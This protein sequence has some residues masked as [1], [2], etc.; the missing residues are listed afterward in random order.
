MS[1]SVQPEQAA[2]YCNLW[3]HDDAFSGETVIFNPDK[4]PLG[5][6]SLWKLVT[7][8]PGSAFVSHDFQGPAGP[9][10]VS[11]TTQGGAT[12]KSSIRKRSGHGKKFNKHVSSIENQTD[13]S[14]SLVFIAQE[15]TAEQKRKQPGLQLSIH[16]SAAATFGFRNRTQVVAIPVDQ[17][18]YSASHVEVSFRDQY[19]ARSDMWRLTVSELSGRSVYKGQRIL[20]MGTVKATV[21]NIYVAGKTVSSACFSDTT[22]PIF[23]SES[24]K[25][26]VF[27][28]MSRE[29]WDFDAEGSGEIMFNKVINGFLP[30][31]FKRWQKMS[32]HHTVSII[33]FTRMEYDQ[34]VLVHRDDQLDDES[35]HRRT[36]STRP[37]FRDYY[38][39]VTTDAASGQ[40]I[41]IL[42]RL[43]REFLVFL[44][45][46]S[47]VGGGD[48]YGRPPE[49]L[50]SV[51]ASANIESV[52]AGQPTTAARGNILEAINLASSQFSKDYIDRDL[53]RTGIS[54]VI[55]TAGT[56]VF[57][58]DYN[59]LKLTTDSLVASGIGVDLVSLARMP[60]HSVPLFRYRSPH[61]LSGMPTVPEI[62]GTHVGNSPRQASFLEGSAEAT[63]RAG[64][65]FSFKSNNE[66]SYPVFGT[67]IE[68]GV[69]WSYALPH[70]IDVSFWTGHSDEANI[71]AQHGLVA[72]KKKHGG[73]HQRRS[74]TTSCRMY[75]LQMMGLMENEMSDIAVPLLQERRQE[76]RGHTQ[77]A[78]KSSYTESGIIGSVGSTHS[79]F[80]A[81]GESLRDGRND[82]PSS[83]TRKDLIDFMSFYDR[84]LF[85]TSAEPPIKSSLEHASLEA[86]KYNSEI[87]ERIGQ[88][89]TKTKSSYMPIQSIGG[90]SKRAD[91]KAGDSPPKRIRPA[92]NET[93]EAFSR[94]LLTPKRAPMNR[95]I[96]LGPRGLGTAKGMASTSIS[97]ETAGDVRS[98]ATESPKLMP[99]APPSKLSS[100]TQQLLS[101]LTRKPSKASLSK[102]E[103][104]DQSDQ[105]DGEL[106]RRVPPSNPI[107]IRDSSL[108]SSDSETEAVSAMTVRQA[109]VPRASDDIVI[110]DAYTVGRQA[111]PRADSVSA[112]VVDKSELQRKL[113]P[114]TAMSPWLTMLNPSNPK[115]HN[116]NI[117]SQFR[118][119]QHVFPK[120]I[121]TSTIK[122]KSLCSPAALPLTAEYFPSAEQLRRE[123]EEYIYRIL[124]L[125]EDDTAEVPRSREALIRELIAFRLANGFQIVVGDAADEFVGSNAASLVKVFDKHYMAD[126][127]ATVLM[128]VG[129]NIHQL[130][131]TENGEIEVRRY[132]RKAVEAVESVGIVDPTV[133]YTPYIR[134]YLAKEYQVRPIIFSNPRPVYK[135]NSIDHYLAGYEQD[136]STDLR[137]WRARFVLIPVDPKIRSGQLGFVSENSDEEI[138]IEGIQKLT[139]TWQRHRYI[140]REERRFQQSLQQRKKDP[141]PLAIE[142]QTHDPSAV[143][144]THAAGLQETLLQGDPGHELF[145]ESEL[146]HTNDFDMQKLSQ[147]LQAD[148][149]KGIPVADRRWHFRLHYK[150]FRGD[151]LTS[152]LLTNFKDIETREDAVKLGNA[153]MRRGLFT[154]A[155]EKH[156]FRDGN[157][158]YQ[159]ASEY[160]TQP[161]PESRAA[162]FGMPGRSV[163]STPMFEGPKGSPKVVPLDKVRSGSGTDESDGS[164]GGSTPKGEQS[165]KRPR[166][167]LS[168]VLRYDVDHRKRSYRPEIINLHYDRIHNPDN[169]YHIR[170]DWM[171]VTAKLIEDAIVQ[172]AASVERYGL[173]LVELPI[174]EGF[175]ILGQH[176]F[177][178]PYI[179]KL[180]VQPPKTKPGFYFESNSFAAQVQQQETH[181]YQ[182]AL[183]RKFDFVL[184]LEA[185]SSFDPGVDV[186]YSWGRP[187]YKYTQF[188]H[189]SG[190][191]LVQISDDGNLMLTANR[192]FVNRSSTAR[193]VGKF[194]RHGS[195]DRRAGLATGAGAPS[196]H[197]SPLMRAGH[198]AA[199]RSMN[200]YGR[201][202]DPMVTPEA[203]NVKLEA[204]C[205]NEK[206]LRAFYESALKPSASPSPRQG[207]RTPVLD[208][209]IPP[210]G[211]PPTITLRN[212]SFME[213]PRGNLATSRRS[214]AQGYKHAE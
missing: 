178:R 119:W 159:V 192:L 26:V 173:K 169:C 197:A 120:P 137:F 34:G 121:S 40:W 130:V 139:Q 21:K 116:M 48:A 104:S 93:I 177:R 37:D 114:L 99:V 77:A 52:I 33:L 8:K 86:S 167:E 183:L 47:I 79:Y 18:A 208:A 212:I 109:S 105:D 144:R 136:F 198:D 24:A 185:A 182:R 9:A 49:T 125:D 100:L 187:D 96:S 43:K 87:V 90:T 17:D 46:V 162:W 32:V 69:Q 89:P 186:T 148:P 74:F 153:L 39:V 107:A 163:P 146:Y 203:V 22:K 38:R 91:W 188:I 68:S 127:G 141:N 5:S 106:S 61:V 16:A 71:R 30:D 58:V 135:W 63:L 78:T 176:P 196:P 168:R 189:K 213:S 35:T 199:P 70:W 118:R 112:S 11:R 201:A 174:A 165:S 2:R 76:E 92:K 81:L 161:Y 207:P 164:D 160:R 172:W 59:M 142:Y 123:Y 200:R 154:H 149:P 88:S 28:Q 36:D 151:H 72:R 145:A 126:D 51:K 102:Y 10:G 209:S 101:S 134:T 138:R 180:A 205:S 23:R 13:Q 3:I 66:G 152:W 190:T 83:A 111:G 158:F 128:T 155:M 124:P 113:S 98:P 132:T 140:P 55:I 179:I 175:H 25:Y 41:D 84:E 85:Q 206:E 191:L 115:K 60:L 27:I 82:E 29:M 20:F 129:N 131:C 170:I 122:W 42:Y 150:C 56:G 6:G 143:V 193:D 64:N 211:L 50:A 44:K 80:D 94:P 166:L 108:A 97:A 31:L 45:D 75:E 117:A 4:L 214:S 133:T 12:S 210:L 14:K 67:A 195:H 53:V 202:A 156:Q 62:G 110:K 103:S 204:F 181:P 19:L 73:T 15:M 157:Y 57:E 54:L 1:T 95:Q 184:D 65:K 147:H 194:D 7:L 171:N